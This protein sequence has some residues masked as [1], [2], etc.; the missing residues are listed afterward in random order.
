MYNQK[1]FSNII[2]DLSQDSKRQHKKINQIETLIKTSN[3]ARLQHLTCVIAP[4]TQYELFI[5]LL[6]LSAPNY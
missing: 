1:Y 2:D 4:S 6:Q 5:L 3:W